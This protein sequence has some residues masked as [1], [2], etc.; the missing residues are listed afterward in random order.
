MLQILQRHFHA[1]YHEV[2][3]GQIRFDLDSLG[4]GGD[5]GVKPHPGWVPAASAILSPTRSVNF[6]VELMALYP[7]SK[8]SIS[9]GP[10]FI[11]ELVRAA[12]AMKPFFDLLTGNA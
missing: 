12:E 11:D 1:R 8:N 2:I 5:S 9:H 3:D 6:Q 10:A 4:K 7:F